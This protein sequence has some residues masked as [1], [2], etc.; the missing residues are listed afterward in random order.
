MPDAVHE[1]RKQDE[2]L[3][4]AALERSVRLAFLLMIALFSLMGLYV[5]F[6]F[7]WAD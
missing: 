5:G 7:V 4:K 6:L 2:E 1:H 3:V